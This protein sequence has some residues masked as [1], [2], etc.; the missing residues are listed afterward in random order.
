[1]DERSDEERT[2]LQPHELVSTRTVGSPSLAE[3]GRG[4]HA[5]FLCRPSEEEEEDL[6]GGG[7]SSLAGRGDYGMVVRRGSSSCAGTVV[8]CGTSRTKRRSTWE[9]T[10]VPSPPHPTNEFFIM[11]SPTY[12][13]YSPAESHA[14][15]LLAR[16]VPIH[17]PRIISSSS[18]PLPPLPSSRFG[19][20]AVPLT[21]WRSMDL[22]LRRRHVGGPPLHRRLLRA[23]K[24]LLRAPSSPTDEPLRVRVDHHVL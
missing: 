9:R 21:E 3:E 12:T 6:V 2:G 18:T 11:V 24:H 19:H 8:S 14:D 10:C 1:M 13:L 15:H 7:S 4:S 22:P 16:S 5:P 17:P 20:A 23:Y